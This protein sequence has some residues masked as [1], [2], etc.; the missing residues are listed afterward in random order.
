M[1]GESD[2]EVMNNSRTS[3]IGGIYFQLVKNYSR[4]LNAHCREIGKVVQ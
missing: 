4:V 3:K 2:V 1:M